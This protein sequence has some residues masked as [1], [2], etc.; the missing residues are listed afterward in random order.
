MKSYITS[1]KLG[2]TLVELLV[3]IAIIGILAAIGIS[4]LN[5]AKSKARDAQRLQ[6]V[7]AIVA[8]LKIYYENNSETWPNESAPLQNGWDSSLSGQANF[9]EVLV[10]QGYLSQV[11]L[12]PINKCDDGTDCTSAGSQRSNALRDHYFYDYILLEDPSTIGCNTGGKPAFVL[13]IRNFETLPQTNPRTNHPNNP[14]FSCSGR[15]YN[16]QFDWV[17][18]NFSPGA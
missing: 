2:F 13:G 6:D 9:L 16:A 17:I 10:S 14:G 7:E 8:A 12:D 11:P 1:P 15:D 5:T 3:V 4:S 18:S